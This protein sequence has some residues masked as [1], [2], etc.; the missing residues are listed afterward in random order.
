M[1][2][3]KYLFLIIVCLFSFCLFNNGVSAK[4]NEVTV[5]LFYGDGCPH[6]SKEKEFLN[7]LV[8]KYENVNLKY[9]EVWYNEENDKLMQIMKEKF[10]SESKGVP[11][12]VIGDN[13]FVGYN[14]NIGY[15]MEET[16]KNLL[17]NGDPDNASKVINDPNIDVDLDKVEFEDGTYVVPILGKINARDVS[18]PILAI[19]LGA[20][21][22]FNPCAM[23]VLLFLI[24]ILIGMKDKKRAFSLGIIFLLA[25]ASVYLIFMVAWLNIAIS[26]SNIAIIRTIV[27]IVALIGAFINLKSFFKKSPDGCTVTD[28]NKRK[29]IFEK[30][31]KFTSEKSF[32]LAA[33]GMVTLAFSVNLIELA[34][35]A[36]LPLLFSQ[37]LAFN[38][39]SGFMYGIYIALYILFFMLDDLIIFFIAMITMK[40]TGVSNKYAKYS[41]LVGGIIMLIIGI[42]LIFNPSILMF[43]I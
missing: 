28:T 22:G 25:S 14:E 30:I 10:G 40:I 32:I 34:C 29:K 9:Y 33:I 17:E 4:E 15:R 31:K 41:H 21:D 3:I 20:V 43:N 11:F 13:S 19:V 16:I 24:S 39:L 37:I 27:A 2:K 6:C 7:K 35:S 38:N 1:K 42:L 8:K 26:M 18:L 5:Y 36:G 23:W 12:T